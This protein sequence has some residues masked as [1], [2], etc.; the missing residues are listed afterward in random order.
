MSPLP[1]VDPFAHRSR[2]YYLW[3]QLIGTKTVGAFTRRYIARL[4]PALMRIT[5][6][7]IGAGGPLATAVLETTG[8]KSG[9]PR[10]NAVLYFHDGQ[11]PVIVASMFGLAN[12]PAWYHNLRAHPQV[13]FGGH[14]YHAELITDTSERT[15]LWNLADRVYPPYAE[16]RRRA[17]E[18]GRTI[19]I[20]RLIGG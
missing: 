14:P 2:A 10:Q 12:N 13:T 3:A 7:R 20:I 11:H 19:P 9:E 4:D 17:D 8:A 1:Y 15:R 18:T 16:Y 5:R 6:G